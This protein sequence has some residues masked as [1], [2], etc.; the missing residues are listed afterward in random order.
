MSNDSGR[1]SPANKIEENFKALTIGQFKMEFEK[2]TRLIEEIRVYCEMAAII[3]WNHHTGWNMDEKKA[4][5][6][7]I[8]EEIISENFSRAGL[9]RPTVVPVRNKD[10]FILLVKCSYGPGAVR[11]YTVAYTPAVGFVY[12]E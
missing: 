6:Q 7:F 5:E 11:E 3:I 8:N 1:S 10:D 2:D 4:L 12:R 9:N